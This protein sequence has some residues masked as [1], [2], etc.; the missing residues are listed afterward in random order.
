L[1][2]PALQTVSGNFSPNTMA[3]LTTVSANALQTVG[4]TVVIAI[5][6]A[7]TTV[8]FANAVS[9]GSTITMNSNL[10]NLVSVTLGTVG[11]LKSIGGTT[12]NISGQKLTAVS[13]NALL[14]LLVSLDGTNGTTTWGS[15]KTLTING[16]T[17]SAPT[18]QGATDK[19][20]LQGRGA[21][22][23]TN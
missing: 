1:S 22:I 12:I 4:G 6:A 20:T 17:N 8:S 14:A 5:M 23:T 13:V 10:G 2:I 9:Y 15:G 21:T 18:G 19:T 3:S 11:T 16:G 7:L